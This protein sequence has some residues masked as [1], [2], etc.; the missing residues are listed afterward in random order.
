MQ[1]IKIDLE[2]CKETIKQIRLNTKINC[3]LGWMLFVHVACPWM[4]VLL[5]SSFLCLHVCAYAFK[6]KVYCGSALGPC[7]SGLHYCCT[8]PVTS[9]GVIGRL[10]VWRHINTKQIDRG[11]KSLFYEL[12]SRNLKIS[13]ISNLRKSVLL[14]L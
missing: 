6:F 7:A 4:F 9:P 12:F 13:E 2:I 3:S 14:I 5:Y 11:K 10:T 8:P 1:Y